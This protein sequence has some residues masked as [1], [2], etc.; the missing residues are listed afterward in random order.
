MAVFVSWD[1]GKG[2]WG[3]AA[4][5]QIDETWHLF[6]PWLDGF[7]RVGV[8]S[9]LIE[10]KMPKAYFSEKSYVYLIKQ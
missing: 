4:M 3:Q 9:M 7:E 6:S 5:V 2:H 1:L 10:E 8:L